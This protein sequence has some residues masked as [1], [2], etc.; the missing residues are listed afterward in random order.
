MARQSQVLRCRSVL[1]DST[2][3]WEQLSLAAGDPSPPGLALQ[4]SPF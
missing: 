1:E 3:K 4:L 2:Q